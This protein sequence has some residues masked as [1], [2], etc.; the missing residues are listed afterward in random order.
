[1]FEKVT[2]LSGKAGEKAKEEFK[3]NG[4][5]VNTP[6]KSLVGIP[7]YDEYVEKAALEYARGANARDPQG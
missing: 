2:T 3:V 1:M 5:Y 7:F 4:Q 6:E